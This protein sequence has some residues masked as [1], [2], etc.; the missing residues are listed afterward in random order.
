MG[1]EVFINYRSEDSRGYAAL[2]YV[3]LARRLGPERV[4]L[5]S[6][7]IPAG[8]DFT[9]H[10]LNQIRHARTV[11]ALI[12]PHWLIATRRARLRRKTDWTCREIVEAF[13]SGRRVV[14]VLTDDVAMPTERQLPDCLAPLARRQYRQLRSHSAVADLDRIAADLFAPHPRHSNR[15]RSLSAG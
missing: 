11:L 8:D 10:L 5:D 6:E 3:E 2:L 14:P 9:E 1:C 7:S 15:T 12:G 13:G 4:F